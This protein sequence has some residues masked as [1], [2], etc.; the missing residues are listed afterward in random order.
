MTKKIIIF[1]A[2]ISGL[3][4]AQ[5]LL[6]KGFKVILIEKDSVIGGHG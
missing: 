2:G 4:I 5:E 6:D 3:T 1:G